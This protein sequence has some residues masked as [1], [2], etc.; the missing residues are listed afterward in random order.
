VPGPGLLVNRPGDWSEFHDPGAATLATVTRIAP[1]AGKAHVITGIMANVLAVNAQTGLTLTLADSSGNRGS[2][3]FPIPPAGQ[4][5]DLTMTGLN[6]VMTTAS[7][8]TVAFNAAPAA[9]N[10]ESITITGYT[11]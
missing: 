3:K 5:R 9:G 1:A 6:I 4:G 10:F 7:A 11:I 8:A 2:W